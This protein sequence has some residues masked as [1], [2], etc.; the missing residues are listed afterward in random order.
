MSNV[1]TLVPTRKKGSV[2]AIR[3]YFDMENK[4]LSNMGLEKYGLS[5]FDGTSHYE[6]LACVERNKIRRYITG[7][8]EFAPEV[9]KLPEEERVA[10]IKVI[11]NTVAQLERELAANILDPEDENFW[12][13]VILLK[14]TVPIAVGKDGNI[15]KCFWDEIGISMG[16]DPVFLNPEDPHDVIKILGIEAGGFSLIA[17][18]LDTARKMAV[19]PKFYLDKNEETVSLMNEGRRVRNQALG[20]LHNLE[21]TPN[22]MFL[23]AKALDPNSVQYTKSTPKDVMYETLDKYI[24]GEGTE[25]SEKRAA[26]N[27]IELCELD[28]ETLKIR[29]IIKDASFHKFIAT[30]SDGHIYYMETNVLMGRTPSDVFEFLKNPLNDALLGELMRK[31]EREWNNY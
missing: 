12:D 4:G 21:N 22:K 31:V 30:K 9:K 7:L 16:N 25:R 1:E 27:F 3:P 15:E 17:K 24:N 10:K 11:R 8:D 14:S 2:I 18:N 20:R 23:V 13:K 29:A 6:Q 28:M 5:T 26:K 19:S